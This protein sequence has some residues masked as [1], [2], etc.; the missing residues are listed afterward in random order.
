MTMLI[1]GL[2]VFLGVHSVS[3]VAPGWRDS[4]AER[5]GPI[6]WRGLFGVAAI[7]GLFLIIRGYASVRDQ[8]PFLYMLPRWVQAITEVLMLPVFPLWLAAFLPGAIRTAVKHPML[9]GIKL[10]ASAHLLA[11]GS[12]ADVVL[13]GSI[14]VWAIADRV[15][16]KRRTPRQAPS[17]PAGRWNDWIVIV[18]GIALYAAMLNGGHAWLIGK[19]LALP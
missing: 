4:L 1:V 14:L 17:F 6:V 5:L 16:L 3:I 7:I 8:T 11:N 2:I 9:A 13:F 19:P 15:S 18:G 12:V 10:W